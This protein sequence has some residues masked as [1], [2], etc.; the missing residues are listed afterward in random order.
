MISA[1]IMPF[2]FGPRLPPEKEKLGLPAVS[3]TTRLAHRRRRALIREQTATDIDWRADEGVASVI[4]LPRRPNGFPSNFVTSSCW[5]FK[6][7]PEVEDTAQ[8]STP[9]VHRG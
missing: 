4:K 7:E 6:L 5:R 2:A 3:L 1:G 9:D 8:T